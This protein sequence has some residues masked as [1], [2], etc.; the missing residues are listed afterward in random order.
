MQDTSPEAARIQAEVQRNL[1][2]ARRAQIALEMSVLTRDTVRNRI[3]SRHPEF[4]DR[5]IMRA[6]V[7]ELY[8]IR[9]DP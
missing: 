9:L 5:E 4:T 8:G 3:R 7:L 1:G 6:L 2:G